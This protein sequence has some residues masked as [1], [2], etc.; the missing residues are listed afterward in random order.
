MG[1]DHLV[2]AMGIPEDYNSIKG[3][4]DAWKNYDRPVFAAKDHSSWRAE[5]HKYTKWHF[6]FNYGDA[7]FCIPPAP[8]KGEVG[9]LNFFM[10]NELWKWYLKSGKLSPKS[11]LTIVNANDSFCQHFDKADKFIKDKLKEENVKVEYGWKLI[12]I[13]ATENLATFE[14]I[15]TGEKVIKPFSNLYTLPPGKP[16]QSLVDAGLATKE[17]NFLLDVDRETL[18]H[19]KYKNIF[20]LGD[21]CNLPTTK[22]FFGGY[23]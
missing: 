3:F 17:S 21:V 1:Y 11:S 19:N 4:E 14:N 2:L 22:S 5:H 18:R 6:N 16:H 10:T 7:Y 15:K 13:H 9:G 8:Y 23:H 20:G 12:E